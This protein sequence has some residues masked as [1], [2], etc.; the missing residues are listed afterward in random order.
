MWVLEIERATLLVYYVFFSLYFYFSFFSFFLFFPCSFISVSEIRRY[1][2]ILQNNSKWVY[3]PKTKKSLGLGLRWPWV[4][5]ALCPVSS[6]DE[7]WV[8]VEETTDDFRLSWL[9][10]SALHPV[11]NNDVL[12]DITQSLA[13]MKRFALNF[14]IFYPF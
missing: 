9:F 4:S 12:N 10:I 7:G 8:F 6:W 13:F 5:C 2:E 1:P 11:R 3:N 14:V